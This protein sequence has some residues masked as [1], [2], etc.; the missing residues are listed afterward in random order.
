MLKSTFMVPFSSEIFKKNEHNS[1]GAAPSSIPVST[2]TMVY[3]F[4]D[5]L[6]PDEKEAIDVVWLKNAILFPLSKELKLIIQ[7]LSKLV[8]ERLECDPTPQF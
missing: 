4:Q 1:I 3:L 8:Q 2:Y 6:R 7:I 5:S